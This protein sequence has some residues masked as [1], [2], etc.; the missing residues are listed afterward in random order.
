MLKQDF[1]DEEMDSLEVD[2]DLVL[3]LQAVFARLA[4][5]SAISE[6]VISH[7]ISIEP[8]LYQILPRLGFKQGAMD[9]SSAAIDAFFGRLP[10]KYRDIFFIDAGVANEGFIEIDESGI[11]VHG[12]SKLNFYCKNLYDTQSCTLCRY[13]GRMQRRWKS[14][15][16]CL[17]E[18]W[19]PDGVY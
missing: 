14:K 7:A 16:K 11:V 12:T 6:D 2:I 17:F 4:M 18:G 13:F 3:N 9:D 5:A 8:D 1:D 15:C 10:K 19:R